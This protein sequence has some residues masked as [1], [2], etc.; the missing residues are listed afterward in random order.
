[1]TYQWVTDGA[2][3]MAPPDKRETPDTLAGATGAD[4]VDGLS[5]TDDQEHSPDRAALQARRA[6]D[7]AHDR[8]ARA[9]A[10]PLVALYRARDGAPAGDL[11]GEVATIWQRL[12]GP[13]ERLVL[14]GIAVQA[15]DDDDRARLIGGAR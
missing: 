12:L 5:K 7:A 2:P 9:M 15:L 11:T 3:T 13:V 14:A 10:A 6:L 8:L 1:M 4:G